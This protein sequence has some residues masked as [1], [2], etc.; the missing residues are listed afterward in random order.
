M[1]SL[2]VLAG[3]RGLE[4]VMLKKQPGPAWPEGHP[5]SSSVA[6]LE[7]GGLGKPTWPWMSPLME[8]VTHDYNTKELLDTPKIID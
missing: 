3:D 4:K 1:I 2:R 8:G 5:P 7:D 6:E